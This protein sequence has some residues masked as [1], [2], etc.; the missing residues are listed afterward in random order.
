MAYFL[1]IYIVRTIQTNSISHNKQRRLDMKNLFNKFQE[2]MVAGT[3]AEAGE[4]NT[5]KEMTPALELSRGTTWLDRIFMAVTFAEYGLHDQALGLLKPAKVRNRG[6]NAALADD[7][8][9]RGIRLMYGTV[10]I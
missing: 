9:L 10:S 7:L 4:W 1:L 3:F 2:T 5:A 8:G 6:F